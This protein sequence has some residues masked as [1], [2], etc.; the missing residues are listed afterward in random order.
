M[1]ITPYNVLLLIKK[2]VDFT[3]LRD[4]LTTRSNIICQQRLLFVSG[5]R[6]VYKKE[7]CRF[8]DV[9]QSGFFPATGSFLGR[10]LRENTNKSNKDVKNE[11]LLVPGNSNTFICSYIDPYNRRDIRDRL[12]VL[13]DVI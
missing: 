5:T 6:L 3:L 10:R 8:W 7:S 11:K 2:R 13:V 12:I 4:I 9:S 1:I